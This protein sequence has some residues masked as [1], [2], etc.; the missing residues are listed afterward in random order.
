VSFQDFG[1]ELVWEIL[2]RKQFIP[3]GWPAAACLSAREKKDSVN[4][5]LPVGML[6]IPN[7]ATSASKPVVHRRSHIF[8]GA[9]GYTGNIC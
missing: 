4:W 8:D 1:C 2:F 7:V 3:M 6:D 5:S 9:E